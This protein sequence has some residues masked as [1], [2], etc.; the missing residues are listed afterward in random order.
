MVCIPT[1]EINS[2]LSDLYEGEPA[3][4][5]GGRKLWQMALY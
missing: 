5:P 2:V 1:K 4:H 3:R